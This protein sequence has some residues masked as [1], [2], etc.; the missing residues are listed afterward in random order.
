MNTKR[1]LIRCFLFALIG[2]LIE[3]FFT[4]F[5]Q[6]LE[7]NWRMTGKTS[8][9]MM[10][11]YGLLGILIM[12]IGEALKRKRVPLPLRAVVYMIGIYVIEYISGTI[13]RAFGLVIWDYSHLPY[14][15]HGQITLAYAPFWWA[16][17]MVIEP[18]YR[19]VDAMAGVLAGAPR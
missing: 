15:L 11:V 3:V 13:F 14:N 16:L 9:W 18:L 5:N 17:G 12:P 7:G 2:L 19:R 6:L 1:V 4:G 8:P 10:P